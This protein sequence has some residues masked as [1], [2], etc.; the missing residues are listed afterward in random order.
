MAMTNPT[1]ITLSTLSRYKDTSVYSTGGI[2]EFGLWVAPKEFESLPLGSLTH[3]VKVN[4]IGMLDMIAVKYYGPGYEVMWWSI[5]EANGI[6]DVE[7]DMYPGQVLVI[8]PRAA[9][10]A[11]TARAG[12]PSE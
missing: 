2:T 1:S 7:I 8:P 9:L 10:I 6:L 5:A 3:V 4:E 11:F 12:E